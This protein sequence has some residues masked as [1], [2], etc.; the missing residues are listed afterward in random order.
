MPISIRK[1]M[2]LFKRK[3]NKYKSN[4]TYDNEFES[5]ICIASRP[6]ITWCYDNPSLQIGRA[7]CRE[8]V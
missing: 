3:D 7:S 5:N 1:V 4:I 8:R 6:N 2:N